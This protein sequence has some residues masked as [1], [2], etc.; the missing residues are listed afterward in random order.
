MRDSAASAQ[1]PADAPDGNLVDRFVPPGMRPYFR[2]ARIDRPIGWWL[3]LLPCWWS[4]LLASASL[5][6]TPAW[7]DLLLLMIGAIAM[8]GAGSTWNDIVDRDLDGRVERTRNRPLP[9]GQISVKQAALSA[10]FLSLV[11]LAVLLSFNNFAIL[12]GFLSLLPVAI[13]PYM[14]RITDYPQAVLGLAFAWGSLMGWAALMASLSLAPLLLY[15]ATILWVVGY[16]TIYA[17][18][19]IEDDGIV[20]IR[21]TARYFGDLSPRLVAGCYAS[22]LALMV[23]TLLSVGA[24]W[25]AWLGLLAFATHLVWQ[26]R[27]VFQ[28]WTVDIADGA[29]ALLLFKSNRDAGLILSFGLLADCFF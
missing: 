5:K 2:M 6:Q 7:L 4:S 13:Y 25:A 3:L 20:G 11:G 16:D 26:I 14:K 15:A 29:R 22:S 28:V 24:G 8:R 27:Q 12:V 18:Q 10:V 19:D 23:M 17:L 21:S 1:K 9:S